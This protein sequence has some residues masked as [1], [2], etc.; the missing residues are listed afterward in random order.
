MRSFRTASVA[1]VALIALTGC[2]SPPSTGAPSAASSTAAQSPSPE[3]PA[4]LVGNWKQSNGTETN[5]QTASI[6][7][8][9]MEIYWVNTAD[10]SKSLYWAGSFTEPKDGTWESVNDTSKTSSAML[11]STAATK[12]FTFKDGEISYEVTALGTTKTVHLVRE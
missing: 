2:S 3:A 8:D 11:A 5:Y 10:E 1:L 6:S 7:A 12:I 4:S 9:T